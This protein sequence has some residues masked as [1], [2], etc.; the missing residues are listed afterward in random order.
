MSQGAAGAGQRQKRLTWRTS[1]AS[2]TPRTATGGGACGL[3]LGGRRRPTGR[4]TGARQ[5]PP[6]ESQQAR[7]RRGDQADET[8]GPKPAKPEEG[9]SANAKPQRPTDADAKP[10][11]EASPGEVPSALNP[12]VRPERGPHERRRVGHPKPPKEQQ[13]RAPARA[14]RGRP[15]AWP[16][17]AEPGRPRRQARGRGSGAKRRRTRGLDTGRS[18][19]GAGAAR[20]HSRL[21]KLRRS[22]SCRPAARS[23]RVH[24]LRGAQCDSAASGSKNASAAITAASSAVGSSRNCVTSSPRSMR[25]ASS[26]LRATMMVIDRLDLGMQ[27][28]GTLCRP[29]VLIG[30]LSAIWLRLTLNPASARRPTRSRGET[31]P[32]S[33]PASEAWRRTVKLL[34]SSLA[35][36]CARLAFERER[37]RLELA[38]HGLKAR[39]V[40]RR[41]AQRLA[42]RQ[43]EIAGEAVLDA[44]H[45]AHLAQS[46]H[47][48]SKITSMSRS[49]LAQRIT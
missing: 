45:F 47:R 24:R 17:V 41:G 32:N 40:L 25:A 12:I 13:T 38:L 21:N 48:S 23:R 35:A 49:S 22:A 15:R 16:V 14:C 29:I 39:A 6:A 10:K 46:G 33:W 43:Q 18:R 7:R 44:H 27:R 34:P 9:A 4:G 1:C 31:D 28:S 5:K 11:E 30:V 3:C 20:Q 2:I 19:R 36:T 26:A 37:A 42:A 8:S